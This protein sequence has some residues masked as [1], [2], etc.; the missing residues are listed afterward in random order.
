MY[1]ARVEWNETSLNQPPHLEV[2]FGIA[3]D[4]P[5]EDVATAVAATVLPAD[6]SLL[7]SHGGA[8]TVPRP[9]TDSIMTQQQQQPHNLSS[10]PHQ[11]LVSAESPLG[12]ASLGVPTGSRGPLGQL[13]QHQQGRNSMLP[14]MRHPPLPRVAQ[15]VS[16]G[17]IPLVGGGQMGYSSGNYSDPMGGIVPHHIVGGGQQTIPMHPYHYH[18]FLGGA[19]ESH[20]MSLGPQGALSETSAAAAIGGN[21]GSWVL[22]MPTG[23][24]TMPMTA[25]PQSPRVSTDPYVQFVFSAPPVANNTGGGTSGQLPMQQHQQITANITR[26]IFVTG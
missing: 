12:I 6:D 26:T 24:Q 7:S 2:P 25:A 23:I 21:Y 15:G 14:S 16:Q 13:I 4:D 18:T 17:V 19:D 5:T 10:N 1:N 3:D 9:G 11:Q 22:N 8:L 20:I